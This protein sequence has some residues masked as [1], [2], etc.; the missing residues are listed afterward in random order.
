MNPIEN[1]QTFLSN[2]TEMALAKMMK[3]LVDIKN[4]F[5]Y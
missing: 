2:N 1:L 5:E 3:L 4:T